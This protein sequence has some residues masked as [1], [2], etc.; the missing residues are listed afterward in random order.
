MFSVRYEMNFE[1]C[2]THAVSCQP[3]IPKARFQSQASPRFSPSTSV[4]PRQYF[5]NSA[6]FIH[7]SRTLCNL[8]D[9]ECR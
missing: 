5:S 6:S 9:L 8:S 7:L 3:R 2:K 1:P 4:F